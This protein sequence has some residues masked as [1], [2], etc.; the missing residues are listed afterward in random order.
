MAGEHLTPRGRALLGKDRKHRISAILKDIWFDCPSTDRILVIAKNM[1][2]AK[3]MNPAPCLLI[4]G[5]G[6]SGKTA[7]IKRIV[8]ES[9]K[10][11]GK[12]A[13]LSMGDNPAGLKF[14][15]LVFHELGLPHDLKHARPSVLPLDLAKI[16]SQRDVRL[17][18]IDEIHAGIKDG[19]REQDISME[20][21]KML[22]APPY[23]LAVMAVGTEEAGQPLA[24]DM[25]LARR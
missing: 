14:K 6:G 1:V 7:L 19:R 8:L 10:W 25:Q 22:A 12:V 21:L 11:P 2:C 3:G 20:F 4:I 5:E 16:I 18:I 23:S 17:I 9:I 15:Q 13:S 24:V